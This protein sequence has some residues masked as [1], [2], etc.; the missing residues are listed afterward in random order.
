MGHT[1]GLDKIS[2][3]EEKKER[4][5]KDQEGRKLKAKLEDDW[6]VLKQV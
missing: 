3:V 6:D 5:G 4:N 2:T 1:E